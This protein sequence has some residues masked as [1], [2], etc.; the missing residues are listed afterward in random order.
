MMDGAFAILNM[1]YKRACAKH[2]A[3]PD[4]VI[5]QAAILGK[6]T[7]E[8]IQAA[9]DHVYL[10]GDLDRV[11][12]EAAQVG[13]MAIR[14]LEA[15]AGR[16]TGRIG[17]CLDCRRR[18]EQVAMNTWKCKALGGFTTTD[19]APGCI[20]WIPRTEAGAGLKKKEEGPATVWIPEAPAYP[21]M[22]AVRGYEAGKN[23]M[24][25]SVHEAMQ[26]ITK[27]NCQTWC[28]EHPIPPYLPR[29]HGFMDGK[30]YPMRG[31]PAG[32]KEEGS[33]HGD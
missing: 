11:R 30:P 28:D 8:C 15:L 17:T 9:I 23:T 27:E 19:H 5:D 4:D 20:L 7:A 14:I 3:F 26:F 31:L 21:G 22:Y 18:P 12:R 13:A 32:Q 25:L 29:E 2:P 16:E 33:R 24:T 1:E 10:G 6:E